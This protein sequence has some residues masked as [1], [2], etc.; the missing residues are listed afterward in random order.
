LWIHC[1]NLK[2]L[3]LVPSETNYFWHQ[4]D[5]FTLTSKGYIWTSAEKKTIDK[6][7][8]VDI[9]PDWKFKNYNCFGVCSDWLF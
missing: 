3:E 6:S 2:A 8:M 1:K 7:I 5:D 9:D 4:N